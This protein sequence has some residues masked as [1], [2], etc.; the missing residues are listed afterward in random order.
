MELTLVKKL[1]RQLLTGLEFMHGAGV[2]HTDVKPDNILY[3]SKKGVRLADLGLSETSLS[4]GEPI[5]TQ[6]YAPPEALFGVPMGTPVDM[7]ALGCTVFEMLTGTLLFDPWT[8]CCA[9]YREFSDDDSEEDSPSADVSEAPAHPSREELDTQEEKREQFRPGAVLGGKYK[10]IQRLGQGKFATV[11]KAVILNETPLKLPSRDAIMAEARARRASLP[12]LPPKARWN[13]YDVA[14]SYE[15]LVQMHELLG[16]APSS[17]IQGHWQKLFCDESSALKFCPQIGHRPLLARLAESLNA[18]EAAEA[19]KFLEG[20]LR[21]DPL[22]RI[23]AAE[24]LLLP[25]VR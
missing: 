14:Q 22:E 16:P 7:W 5:A 1:T 6:D 4:A 18:E 20:L 13:L 24:A 12:P 15:H 21:Y 10:L 9:K 17:V 11:W 19:A 2:I 3:H 23:T 25:W 8:A